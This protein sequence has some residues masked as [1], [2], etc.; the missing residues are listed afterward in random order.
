MKIYKEET[1]VVAGTEVNILDFHGNILA[2]FDAKP[3][4]AVRAALKANK[5][6]WNGYMKC[7]IRPVEPSPKRWRKQ[8]ATRAKV[9]PPPLPVAAGNADDIDSMLAT[10]DAL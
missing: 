6:R 10:L 4:E 8:T 3:N 5:F 7:W 9:S 2:H 1:T